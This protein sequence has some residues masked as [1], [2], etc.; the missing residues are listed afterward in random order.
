M[1]VS[2]VSLWNPSTD[3]ILNIVKK[4]RQ[5]AK[6]D[7]NTLLFKSPPKGTDLT[8][9]DLQPVEPVTEHLKSSAIEPSSD[10]LQELSVLM[11]DI[12]SRS[13]FLGRNSNI[14]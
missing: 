13:D 5:L 9:S 2:Q 12:K 6:P 8:V 1:V 14:I 4:Q 3:R 11:D 10:P 7:R